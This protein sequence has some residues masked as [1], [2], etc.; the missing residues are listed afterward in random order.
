MHEYSFLFYLGERVIRQHS[1]GAELFSLVF[2][3]TTIERPADTP[4]VDRIVLRMRVHYNHFLMD[5]PYRI[6]WLLFCW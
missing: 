1:P 5:M 2:P 4:E 3:P 6:L